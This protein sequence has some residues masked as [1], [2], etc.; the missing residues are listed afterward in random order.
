MKK[1]LI[2][3]AAAALSSTAHATPLRMDYAVTDL[4]GGIWDYEFYLTLDNNDNSW[5]YGNG[6]GWVIIGDA[7]SSDSPLYDWA[8]DNGDFPVGP[9]VATS[10]NTE[11]RAAAL[12]AGDLQVVSRGPGARGSRPRTSRR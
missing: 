6:W 9:H 2:V 5:N 4:G 12:D 8:G 7:Q 11:R 3:L 1:V 10:F